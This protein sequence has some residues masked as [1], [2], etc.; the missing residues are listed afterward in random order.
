MSRN[1]STFQQEFQ[2]TDKE[3]KRWRERQRNGSTA[4]ALWYEWMSVDALAYSLL[5]LS[6]LSLI[7]FSYIIPAIYPLI[8]YFMATG[9]N[10][11]L[12]CKR[13]LSQF[14]HFI[15]YSIFLGQAY[16]CVCMS[17][18]GCV[19]VCACVFV[20][21]GRTFPTRWFLCSLAVLLAILAIAYCNLHKR[22]ALHHPLCGRGQRVNSF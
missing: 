22:L 17:V 6:R 7:W 4:V 19:W 1:G 5:I 2:Q 3:I 12:P 10:K 11:H 8:H 20:C 21:V 14:R 15:L 18:C 9:Y 16:V 13:A